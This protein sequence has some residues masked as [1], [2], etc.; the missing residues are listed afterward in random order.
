MKELDK[1]YDDVVASLKAENIR[2]FPGTP[3]FQEG[4]SSVIMWDEDNDDWKDFVEI[5]KSEGVRSMIVAKTKGRGDHADETGSVILAWIKDGVAYVFNKRADWWR[6]EAEEVEPAEIHP[7]ISMSYGLEIPKK[8]RKQLQE[9]SPEELA[10]ELV[11]FAS[12]EFP[13]GRGEISTSEISGLFWQKKGLPY[14]FV[15]DPEIK[16]KI[17]KVEMIAQQKLSSDILEKPDEE[18]TNEA[19]DFIKKQ[20][21]DAP[22]P[23]RATELFWE[24]KGIRR[25]TSDTRLRLKMDKVESMVRQKLEEEQVEREKEILPGLIDEC[26]KW[27]TRNQLRKLTK[28]NVDYFLTEKGAQLSRTTKDALYNQ[29]NFKLAKR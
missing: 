16:I 17:R 24:S 1:M 5:A 20:F 6:E 13:E 27:A 3:V 26:L 21:K 11:E 23:Y 8:L 25:F 19:L 10:D 15:E 12:K 2:I 7:S 29:V 9:K 28:S 18:L 4:L 14:G 22:V